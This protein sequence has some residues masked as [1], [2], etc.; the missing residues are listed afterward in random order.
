MSEENHEFLHTTVQNEAAHM[1]PG[2]SEIGGHYYISV[3]DAVPSE[4]LRGPVVI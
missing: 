2:G 1:C 4:N 3:R